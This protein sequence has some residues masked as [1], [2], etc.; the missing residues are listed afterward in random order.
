MKFIVVKIVNPDGR[1]GKYTGFETEELA[2]AHLGVVKGQ[3]PDAF[4]TP[5]PSDNSADW[6]IDVKAKTVS[7]V[8]RKVEEKKPDIDPTDV[9][10]KGAPKMKEPALILLESMEA[11]IR[12]LEDILLPQRPTS[13][14]TV[15][16]FQNDAAQLS[17]ANLAA[18]APYGKPAL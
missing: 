13:V 4:V 14:P 12:R 18:T 17:L 10:G 3:F 1:I 9:A 15:N 16:P 7:L 2:E 5:M 6:L 8:P 11:R